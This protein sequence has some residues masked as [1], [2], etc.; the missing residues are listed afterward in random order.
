[1][2]HNVLQLHY[3]NP[4]IHGFDD[5]TLVDL[6]GIVQLV[7]NTGRWPISYAIDSCRVGGNLRKF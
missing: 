1:M 2:F 3:S 5:V 7:D 6:I 4:I